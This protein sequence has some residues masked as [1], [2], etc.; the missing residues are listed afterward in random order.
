M[1]LIHGHIQLPV[2]QGTEEGLTGGCMGVEW[3]QALGLSAPLPTVVPDL[4]AGSVI[5]RPQP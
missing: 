4:E 5:K 1:A 3:L 2:H